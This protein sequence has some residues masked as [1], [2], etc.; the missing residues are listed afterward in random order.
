MNSDE[1]ISGGPLTDFK[2]TAPV[3]VGKRAE[4]SVTSVLRDLLTGAGHA[5]ASLPSQDS[6][7]EDARFS[8]AGAPYTIQVTAIPQAPAFWNDVARGSATTRVSLPQVAGWL[9][10]AINDKLNATSKAERPRTII[11]LDAH[12]W[13]DRVI[14]PDVV[15]KLNEQG[16]NPGQKHGLAGIAIVG[17]QSSNSTWL[18]GLLT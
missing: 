2:A 11:A 7:G 14:A 1:P 8:I 3:T 9:D 12:D 18:P 17:R 4:A 16:L 13:A 15:S 6:R 5:V 10:A